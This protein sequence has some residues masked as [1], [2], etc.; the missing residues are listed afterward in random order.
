MVP[1]ALSSAP[2]NTVVLTLHHSYL[3]V[4]LP[5]KGLSSQ[6]AKALINLCV[7]RIKHWCLVHNRSS[8]YPLWM[9]ELMNQSMENVKEAKV[10]QEWI[11]VIWYLACYLRVIIHFR[12]P[13]FDN[14]WYIK[15]NG[16]INWN[17][18]RP[19]ILLT[20]SRLIY[21]VQSFSCA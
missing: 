17:R 7:L 10:K 16:N 21:L 6:K 20:G 3:L 2:D 1:K 18:N 9:T 19:P 13:S 11:R 12:T 4:Y 14:Y 15:W 8:V 5:H